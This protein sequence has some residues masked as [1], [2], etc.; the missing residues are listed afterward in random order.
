MKAEEIIRLYFFED[1]DKN[2]VTVKTEM[3]LPYQTMIKD[4]VRPVIQSILELWF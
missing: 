1:E 4:F 2:A 3:P